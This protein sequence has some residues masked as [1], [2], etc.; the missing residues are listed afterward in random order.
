MV[1]P[2]FLAIGAVT[3]LVVLILILRN[4]AKEEPKKP[5]KKDKKQKQLQAKQQK[6]KKGR[7]ALKKS[8]RAGIPSE[9]HVVGDSAAKDASEVLEFLKG[10]DPNEI[11]KQQ[12]V[13]TKTPTKKKGS[14]KKT[15]DEVQSS[16]DSATD[17][18]SYEG[19]EEVKK[20]VPATDKK[21]KKKEERKEKKQEGS[22]D[23]SKPYFKAEEKKDEK[24]KRE[25]KPRKSEGEGPEGLQ[26]DGERRE[27][28]E[29][30]ERKEGEG[31]RKREPR[32]PKEPREPRAEPLR[33][34]TSAP[35]VKYEEQAGIDEILNTIT[36]DYKPKKQSA[37]RQPSI[38]SKIERRVVK[39]ILGYLTARD[40]VSLSTVNHH[41]LAAARNDELWKRLCVKDFGINEKDHRRGGFRS[42]YRSEFL[43][44]KTHKPKKDGAAIPRGEEKDTKG[45][46]NEQ[47]SKEV[48]KE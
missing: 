25:R 45:K 44:K 18:G 2:T 28:R 29:P 34:V 7:N 5:S 10:K 37:A 36:Q 23:N 40:L 26:K 22:K 30:R 6:P 32:P 41:F 48:V 46:K 47:A 39:K 11:A 19:F 24:G 43:G 21:K 15:K 4:G 14:N 17:D 33:P 38:F 42:L 31:E 16:E 3:F 13:A 35:N 1:D 20:K 27:R 12:Q 9:W 8:E